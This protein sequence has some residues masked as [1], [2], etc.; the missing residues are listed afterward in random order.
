MLAPR[1]RDSAKNN[2]SDL[3]SALL[4]GAAYGYYGG[5]QKDFHAL[6]LQELVKQVVDGTLPVQ[7]DRT[8]ISMK[9]LRSIELWSRILQ[10]A[11][12]WC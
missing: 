2:N 7:I 4:A 1:Y 9:L 8:F 5:E 3:G 10:V 11:R 12:L 6:P